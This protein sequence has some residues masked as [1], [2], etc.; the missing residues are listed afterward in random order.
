MRLSV[1][2]VNLEGVA[3]RWATSI[4]RR[5]YRVVDQMFSGTSTEITSL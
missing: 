1:A 2:R 5:V 4:P 3:K